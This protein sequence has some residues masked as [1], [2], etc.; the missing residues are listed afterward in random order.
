MI[1]SWDVVLTPLFQLLVATNVLKFSF[2]EKMQSFLVIFFLT[3]I[4]HLHIC[5]TANACVVF[6]DFLYNKRYYICSRYETGYM[7]VVLCTTQHGF[8]SQFS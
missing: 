4:R 3:R 5:A 8:L 6:H 2:R 1:A 7:K